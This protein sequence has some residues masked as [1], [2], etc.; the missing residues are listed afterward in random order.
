MRRQGQ[1][2]HAWHQRNLGV[3]GY[4]PL[5]EDAHPDFSGFTSF[6]RGLHPE[7]NCTLFRRRGCAF[8]G[9]EEDQTCNQIP[10]SSL[11][12][13][14]AYI[15]CQRLLVR[16]GSEEEQVTRQSMVIQRGKEGLRGDPIQTPLLAGIKKASINR[17]E[18]NR[19]VEWHLVIVRVAFQ[20]SA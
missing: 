17:K 6:C 3:A 14:S 11:S 12:P 1:P 13:A 9:G 7:Y 18:N 8:V 19:G 5:P 10:D 4:S 2:S 20:A 15:V 16:G